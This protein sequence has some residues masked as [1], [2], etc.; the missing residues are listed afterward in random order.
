M[1]IDPNND[2]ALDVLLYNYSLVVERVHSLGISYEMTE[3]GYNLT[4]RSSITIIALI[5]K[6]HPIAGAAARMWSIHRTI[7]FIVSAVTTIGLCWKNVL[8]VK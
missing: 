2:D 6:S 4:G 3:R 8:I 5:P 1:L 7:F